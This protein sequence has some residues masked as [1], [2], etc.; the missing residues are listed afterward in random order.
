MTFS[1]SIFFISPLSLAVS[2]PS[3]VP[4]LFSSLLFHAITVLSSPTQ[5]P[6]FPC[7][8]FIFLSISSHTQSPFSTCYS[9]IFLFIISL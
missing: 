1:S 8:S 7:Y 2:L 9:F 5:S 4:F 6:F 3:P